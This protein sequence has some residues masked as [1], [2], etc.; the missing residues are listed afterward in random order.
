MRGIIF[1]LIVFTSLTK[2][3]AQELNF[4]QGNIIDK[5]TSL[6]I[7]Y[8]S[9]KLLNS[10][11]TVISNTEGVFVFN[12]KIDN[13]DTILITSIGFM[14]LKIKV[15]DINIRGSRVFML[16]QDITLLD[17]VKI[18]PLVVT[19]VLAEAIKRSSEKYASPIILNGFYKEYVKR[20]SLLAKYADGI[21]SYYI[22]KNKDW[23][24]KIA[25]QI[26]ES[27]VKEIVLVDEED[28][29]NELGTPIS[30]KNLALFATPT[31]SPV[32]DSSNFKNY[33]FSML[34]TEN[35]KKAAYIISFIPVVGSEKALYAGKIYI[36]K[37]TLLIIGLDYTVAPI[38]EPYLKEVNLL[39]Y[40]I[41]S[42][43]R[44]VSARYKIDDDNYYLVYVGK[45]FGMQINSKRYNQTNEFK[46]EFWLIE[47]Q[48]KDCVPFKNGYTKNALYKR[49]TNYNT[50]FWNKY[51]FV[52]NTEEELKFLK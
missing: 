48:T 1:L 14:P 52:G 26:N 24:P 27:R 4:F 34:E 37:T 43:S 36:D 31:A 11:K 40:R 50:E 22:K 10:N 42:T 7:P 16:E 38:S 35:N 46:S 30:I 32:M 8:C 28:K 2:L 6:P 29:M 39:G 9:I 20:D 15:K 5:N 12:K 18:K 49:G 23:S 51:D 33:K 25:L 17:E 41:S 45:S 21:I 47:A 13:G 3:N 44:L 19:Q